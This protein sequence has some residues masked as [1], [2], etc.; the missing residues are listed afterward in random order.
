M[1]I[2]TEHRDTLD[3]LVRRLDG[4]GFT[5]QIAQIHG[6]M[7]YQERE[8][9]VTRF[10]TPVAEGGAKYMVATDAAGEGINLQVCWL[11]VNYDIPWNP[12]RLEQRMGR[13]HRYGQ[14][15]DP[16]HIINLIAGK[17]REGRV[18]QTLLKKLESIRKE[19]SSDKVFDVVGRFFE[20][21]SLRE[22]MEQVALEADAT[23]VQ[24]RIEGKLT[25]EQVRAW[26]ERERALYGDG[27]AV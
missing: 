8:E 23:N 25:K 16:V 18:M 11:M 15:H 19:L 26:Q 13:I 1:I 10:R 3:S 22:Y 5:G 21:I 7:N 27:G 20:D 9:Q 4:L 14:K 2:F 17:T 12:A 6:G 24:R